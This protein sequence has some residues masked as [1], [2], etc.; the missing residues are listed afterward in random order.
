MK[1]KLFRS[2]MAVGIL[3]LL[4]ALT[5]QGVYTAQP[6]G[7]PWADGN[8]PIEA[9]IPAQAQ[10]FATE[11]AEVSSEGS[12]V[13]YGYDDAGRLIKAEY[14]TG[15][16]IT[17][18]YDAAGNMLTMEIL[19]KY[20]TLALN[21]PLTKGWNL[22]SV[23]LN[24]TSW[25]LGEE[26]VVGDPLNVTP[27]NSLASIYR[28]NTTSDLFE[29]CD[30]F[31]DWGWWQATGSES[32]AE[33]EPGRGYWVMAKSECNLTFTGTPPSE[34][35]VAL[36]TGWN[37]IGRY[38]MAEALLGQESVVGDPLNVTPKNSLSSIYMYNCST[39]IFEKCDHFDDWGWWPATGSESFTE[40]EPGRG[41]WVMA[42]NDCVWRHKA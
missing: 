4:A 35:N 40:L 39:G 42:K 5:T 14:S 29:K 27:K 19:K 7:I 16:T 11:S 36:D 1:S 24:L 10:D 32:F 20:P 12:T 37:L 22:I 8:R 9:S 21:I 33:L 26:S 34:L 28:Y 25:D 30:H 17:Y 41:Y 2:S 38:A 23:P 6:E 31:D 15:T 3:V 18:T 13:V